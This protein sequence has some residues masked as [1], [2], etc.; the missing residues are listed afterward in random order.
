MIAIIGAGGHGK[1]C[2]ECFSASSQPVY[3]FYD[4]GPAVTGEEIIDGHR[5]RGKP[6]LILRENEITG[7][8]VAIGDNRVR[9]EKYRYF[10]EQGYKFPDA[11][12]PRAYI[13]PFSKTGE[14]LFIMGAAIVNPDAVTGDCCIINTNATVGHDCRLGSSVQ[15]A[16]G[17][18]IGGGA[19]LEEGVFVGI[20]ARIAPG[21]RIGEWSVIG[22][23][24]VVLKDVPP[25]AFACGIPASVKKELQR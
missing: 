3:G 12:H 4:D 19:V 17:V 9:L 6:S 14:G 23:G 15:V 13:S 8:F 25:R 10:K 16:P 21:V 1:C 24:A 7:I 2:Y 20:G 18:N 11:V 5:V 22:A